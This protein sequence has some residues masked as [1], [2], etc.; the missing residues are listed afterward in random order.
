MEKKIMENWLLFRSRLIIEFMFDNEFEMNQSD[1]EYFVNKCGK[2]NL[3]FDNIIIN[4]LKEE[5]SKHPEYYDSFKTFNEYW[6]E[7][8]F[9]MY[10]DT[11]TNQYFWK[12]QINDYLGKYEGK[13]FEFEPKHHIQPEFKSS[14]SF[15]KIFGINLIV[16]GIIYPILHSFF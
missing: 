8:D 14:I 13:C 7:D 1:Y 3:D 11:K 5:Y 10:E 9:E 4:E 15:L 2:G 6:E 16:C 12:Y